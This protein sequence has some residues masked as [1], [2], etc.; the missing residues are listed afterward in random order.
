MASLGGMST[1]SFGALV[2][3]DLCMI[4]F[5]WAAQ[6]QYTAKTIW[7]LFG[8]GFMAQIAVFAMLFLRATG[9]QT[10]EA[11]VYRT[12]FYFVFI[13]WNLV[14]LVMILDKSDSITYSGKAIGYVVTEV[15]STVP[16]SILTVGACENAAGLHTFAATILCWVVTGGD[17]AHLRKDAARAELA[18]RSAAA[19]EEA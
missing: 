13:T 6:V 18:M 4:G 17:D 14:T 15:L 9:E 8:L 1:T 16:F 11:R 19:S 2:F 7:P 3:F 5:G 12:L 10:H